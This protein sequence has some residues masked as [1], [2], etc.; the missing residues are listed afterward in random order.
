MASLKDLHLISSGATSDVY[1]YDR[2]KVLKVFTHVYQI[3]SVMYEANIT[4]I[5]NDY[6]IKAPKYHDILHIDDRVGILYDYI[7]GKLLFSEL[8]DHPLHAFRL[9]KKLAAIQHSLNEYRSDKLPT[10]RDRFS[11]LIQLVTVIPKYRELLL[12]CLE[13]IP[14]DEYICHGDFHV[15]N[16]IQSK[17]GIFIIDWMNCYTGAR[18]GD[19]VRSY[20]ML[21]SPFIPIKMNY[22]LSRLFLL[23][24]KI[25]GWVYLSEYIKL[26]RIKKRSLRKWW[27]LV[28]AA[29]LADKVPGEEKWLVQKIRKNLKYLNEF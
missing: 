27:P 9:I 3:E 1:R 21:I 10:Q 14:Q 18:E 23:Q 4:S 7:P 2:D 28:A 17:D 13:K 25:I 11:Y 15:G 6:A 12:D 22:I 5:I 29:R 24:K 16:L 26:S 19:I 8:L 20:L